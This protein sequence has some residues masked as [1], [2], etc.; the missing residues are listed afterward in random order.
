MQKGGVGAA[1][2][3]KDFDDGKVKVGSIVTFSKDSVAKPVGK[4]PGDH[5]VITSGP[6]STTGTVG[7][8]WDG[9]GKGDG[10]QYTPGVDL[11]YPTTVGGGVGAAITKKDFDDGKVK[12]GSTVTFSKDSAT[13]PEGK[14]PGD[15]G[16]VTTG[17]DSSTGT[18]GVSWDGSGRGDGKQYKP[19]GD[20]FYTLVTASGSG[21]GGGATQPGGGGGEKILVLVSAL[22]VVR[23]PHR[24]HVML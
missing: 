24:T 20:L 19:D 18:V 8:S 15:H 13:K 16:V 11:F 22:P 3:K 6:D 4:A 12:V 1:I 10:K 21:G 14:A 17:L 9:S 5:G 7:V 23:I 2:T